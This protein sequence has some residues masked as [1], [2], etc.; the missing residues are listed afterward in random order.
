VKTKYKLTKIIG[1]G[2]YG[3][4]VKA[5]NRETGNIVA[6]KQMVKIGSDTL[7]LKSIIREVCMLRCFSKVSDN[8]HTSQLLDIIAPEDISKTEKPYLFLVMDFVEMDLL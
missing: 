5:K 1:R 8:P 4:I 3:L 2:T 7:V 6:V